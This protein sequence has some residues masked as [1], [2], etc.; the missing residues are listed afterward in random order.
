[1]NNWGSI[2]SMY[3]GD[4]RYLNEHWPQPHWQPLSYGGTRWSYLYPPALRYGTA[5]LARY[6]PLST[7]R[8]YHIYIA[9]LYCLGIAGVYLLVRLLSDSRGSAWLAAAGALLTSPC[10]LFIEAFRRNSGIRVPQRLWVLVQWGEGPH[11]SAFAILPIALA[12]SYLALERWRPGALAA[13]AVACA[14][15]V[16]NNFYGMTALSLSFAVLA[17]TLWVTRR[18]RAMFARAAL[19]AGLAYGLT[20]IWLTPSYLMVTVGN[21]RLLPRPANHTSLVIGGVLIGLLAV[22]ILRIFKERSER[23]YIAFVSGLAAVWVIV[24]LGCHFFG[25]LM[26]GDPYRLAPEL[27]L[28]LILLGAEGLRRLWISSNRSRLVCGLM[29]L[30]VFWPSI[31]YARRAWTIFPSD[32]T[33]TER[34][35][36]KLTGWIAEHHPQARVMTTGSLRFWFNA[37]HDLAQ[38]GGG[39][40]QG[41]LNRAAF[42]AAY[43]IIVDESGERGV[44]WAKAFGVDLIAVHGPE[45]QEIYHD[46]KNPAK[47][48][49]LLPVA[50]DDKAGNVIYSVP[51]RYPGL[52]RVVETGRIVSLDPIVPSEDFN[53]VTAYVD[54]LE[55]G[56]DAPV[57]FQ[58]NGPDEMRLQAAVAPGQSIV[59]EVSY[60]RAWH[61][62]LDG[63]P[64]EVRKDPLGQMLILTP[65]GEQDVLLRWEQPL[66]N[67]IGSLLTA[68]SLLGVVGLT[69][70]G[71]RR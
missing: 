37:W 2:E 66:E 32:P 42:V 59:V 17:W 13:A 26:T 24:V 65:P 56:P 70:A 21:L 27:D 34:V 30:A 41:L 31:R 10:F 36:Y 35:E 3:I 28:A 47:F 51:R 55:Q 43:K 15:V 61:A 50:F 53:T 12:L 49:D 44:E 7:A 5:I 25:L 46:F 60:D 19:I 62:Y 39:A 1:M 6:L 22:L 71:F 63:R 48:A 4:S 40:D 54:A 58:W 69:V 33:P 16:S 67:K 8:A 52:G 23:F 57:A 14:L 64:L 45:S 29:V 11:M 38:L 68:L 20:A 18:P 9:I